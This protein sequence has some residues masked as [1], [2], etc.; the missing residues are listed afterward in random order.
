[1]KGLRATITAHN[2]KA[3]SKTPSIKDM[4]TVGPTIRRQLGIPEA[5]NLER[6]KPQTS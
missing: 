6:A 4:P 3:P 1:M 5:L 2:G